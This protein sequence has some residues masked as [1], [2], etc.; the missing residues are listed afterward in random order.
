[1]S[2]RR[3]PAIPSGAQLRSTV[4]AR[5]YASTAV[6]LLAV[7]MIVAAVRAPNLFTSHGLSV[8]ASVAAPIVLATMA[9]TPVAIS[10]RGGIDLSVGP[11]MGFINVTIVVW[12]VG[13]GVTNPVAVIGFA[14]G[15]A[16]LVGL[17]NGLLV[18]V[19]RLQPVIATLGGY[20]MLTGLAV[21]VLP[22]AGGAVPTW[23]AKLAGSSGGVPNALLVVIGAWLLWWP[24][25]RST[26]F[27]HIRAVGG[28][29]R[30]AFASGVAIRPV[31]IAA[32]MIGGLFSGLA[33]LMLTAVL[34][35]GDATQGVTYTL[36]SVAALALG[37]VSLAGGRGGMFG[38]VVGALDVYLINYVL[39]TFDFGVNAPYVTQMFYGLVLVL[40]L[41]A[42]GA[43]AALLARRR[44]RAEVRP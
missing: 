9:L 20:L 27:G 25:S 32:Y 42:A 19:V 16:L 33:A 8:A 7:L 2:A 15:I 34:A 1:M 5:T 28:D 18:A 17:I 3:L 29:E 44:A 35:S 14:I 30:A 21:Y 11:L 26:L 24:I 37:G 40:A 31:Q 10:G 22:A 4:A 13:N 23:L 41:I 43:G 38:A 12:L 6:V 39:G 36:T